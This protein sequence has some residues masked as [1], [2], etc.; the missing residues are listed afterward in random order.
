[1]C[2]CNVRR[3]SEETG[4]LRLS[5]MEIYTKLP[6]TNFTLSEKQTTK[7]LLILTPGGCKHWEDKIIVDWDLSALSWCSD[8][9]GLISA[10]PEPGLTDHIL[11]FPSPDR[12]PSSPSSDN[13][14]G[15][16]DPTLWS[17]RPG[18]RTSAQ[19]A[20]DRQVT[21]W[22]AYELPSHW[23]RGLFRPWLHFNTSDSD[24]GEGG[25]THCLGGSSRHERKIHSRVETSLD[26]GMMIPTP[27]WPQLPM[28]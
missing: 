23:T 7:L 20:P 18:A 9:S 5:E 21:D 16:L 10:D 14:R 12:E 13:G 4:G 11:P 8:S 15:V 28:W 27:A 1:M 26:Q 3:G 6:I 17:L 2:M 25:W 19:E 22:P 24:E